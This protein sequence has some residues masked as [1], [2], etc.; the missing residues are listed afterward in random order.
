M[1]KQ[2]LHLDNLQEVLDSAKNSTVLG[3]QQ[4][5]TPKAIAAA[6]CGPLPSFRPTVTDFQCGH[7]ALLDAAANSTTRK[8]IGIDIDPTSRAGTNESVRRERCVADFTQFF[9]ML[10]AVE[11]KFDLLVLNPPYSLSW[12]TARFTGSKTFDDFARSSSF[13]KPGS[14]KAPAIDSTLATFLCAIESLSDYYGEGMLICNNA[15]C[16]RLLEPNCAFKHVWLKLVLPNF[17]PGT[18][19]DM[20]IAVIYF[21]K[22]YGVGKHQT[23]TLHDALP[24]SIRGAL[25]KVAIPSRDRLYQRMESDS[26]H[27]FQAAKAEY[28]RIHEAKVGAH[29]GF[30]IYLDSSG[31]LRGYLTPFQNLSG[32]ISREIVEELQKLDGRRIMELVIM[33]DTR[34]I[35]SRAVDGGVW[36]VHPDVPP[37][38]QT[39]LD[40]YET[41]RAPLTPLSPIHRLGYLDENEEIECRATDAAF[42]AGQRYPLTSETVPIKLSDVR[43]KPSYLRS[44][45][46]DSEEEVETTGQDLLIR[47]RDAHGNWH[48][49]TQH[50]I[51]ERPDCHALHLLPALLQ[52]FVIP[53][54]KDVAELS[55]ERYAHFTR[56]LIE[57]E[58]A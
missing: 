29:G 18:I 36:R 24:D 49:F 52:R 34:E 4:F 8:L 7:G 40:D 48:G 5:T 46:D 45:P 13:G 43:K 32:T 21:H 54:V 9:P 53:H 17:F 16:K 15:T 28:Q 44:S 25:S 47:I 38:L 14:R 6:L 26:L 1:R 31:F 37:A 35:L 2:S 56:K 20:Q 33:R 51:T 57:L 10:R 50:P 27:A 12:D 42:T 19:Q 22:G 58:A 41:A 55:P 23:I 11:A 39:A 3:T 30:N